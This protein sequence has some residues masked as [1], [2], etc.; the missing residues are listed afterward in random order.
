MLISN[1]NWEIFRTTVGYA[2][3]EEGIKSPGIRRFFDVE[4]DRNW[5]EN[6]EKWEIDG[7]VLCI[8]LRRIWKNKMF[9]NLERPEFIGVWNRQE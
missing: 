2:W 8:E 1:W 6:N 7:T 5:K 9:L 4:D 3:N